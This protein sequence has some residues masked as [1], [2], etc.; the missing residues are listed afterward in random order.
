MDYKGTIYDFS[1]TT[2]M[3]GAWKIL[4]II[5]ATANTIEKKR[6]V[7]EQIRSCYTFFQC[8]KCKKHFGQYLINHPPEVEIDKIDGLFDWIIDFMNVIQKRLGKPLYEKKILY[9]MFHENGMVTCNDDCAEND[10]NQNKNTVKRTVYNNDDYAPND[11]PFKRN[12]TPK[13]RNSN[14]E[15]R[16][17]IRPDP[18]GF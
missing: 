15:G 17:Y 12:Y 4:L 14:P 10:E 7:C 9:P 5:T 3:R 16:R 13:E 1:D 2:K 8:A 11:D 6:I 18:F